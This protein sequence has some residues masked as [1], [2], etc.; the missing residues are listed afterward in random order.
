MPHSKKSMQ[1]FLGKIN[2]V[3]RF[4]PGFTEIVRPLQKMIKKYAEFKWSAEEKQSFHDILKAIAEAPTLTSPNFSKTFI[5]YTFASDSSY[6]AV[7]TQK[8]Q[9]NNEA[10]FAFTSSGLNGAKLN[11]PEVDKQAFAIFKS[12]KHFRPYLLKSHTKV[13]VPYSAVKN[14]FTLY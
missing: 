2:F 13:I 10:P 1:S 11:Y 5:L 12:V 3:S 8:N 9:E 4:I 7:L 14:L 6:A